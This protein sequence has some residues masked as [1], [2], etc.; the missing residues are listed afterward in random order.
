M[1]A[2]GQEDFAMDVGT[3]A[4]PLIQTAIIVLFGLAVMASAVP[5]LIRQGTK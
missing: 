4:P 3:Q 5:K 2:V 1:G